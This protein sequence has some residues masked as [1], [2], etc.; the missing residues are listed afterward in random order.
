MRSEICNCRDSESYAAG[1]EDGA[2][3]VLQTLAGRIAVQ[4][5]VDAGVSPG[6]VLVT[7]S[8]AVLDVC[9]AGVRAKVVR[10]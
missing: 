6:A 7:S 4:V 3:A 1:V 8:A 5:R 9:G 10:S 2:G